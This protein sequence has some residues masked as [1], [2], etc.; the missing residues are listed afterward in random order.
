M[1]NRCSPELLMVSFAYP[2]HLVKPEN[3]LADFIYEDGFLEDWSASG[4]NDDK[5]LWQFESILT[6]YPEIGRVIRGT[7][8]LRKVRW[9]LPGRGKSGGIRV[10]YQWFPEVFIFYVYM[11][12]RKSEQDNLSQVARNW[13][14]TESES[15]RER[16]LLAYGFNSS[17]NRT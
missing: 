12:Y 7:G 14:K 3:H 1:S 6:A 10:I 13:L 8:G 5:D 17:K 15:V 11:A 2:E 16:L 9:S 4:L